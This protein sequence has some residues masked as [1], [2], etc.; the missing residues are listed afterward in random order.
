MKTRIILTLLLM[1]PRVNANPDDDYVNWL[2]SVCLVTTSIGL[3]SLAVS[4][5][6]N[7]KAN[8]RT[9]ESLQ[10]SQANIA[11]QQLRIEQLERTVAA[12]QLAQADIRRQQLRVDRLEKAVAARQPTQ[13]SLSRKQRRFEG[14]EITGRVLQETQ[15]HNLSHDNT[16]TESLELTPANFARK[17]RR[18]E[19]L[20]TTIGVRKDTREHYYEEVD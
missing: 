13:A 9:V 12:H 11:R 17:Q 2:Q 8:Q 10:Q 16:E 3:V 7:A 18:L 4:N 5:C 19:A 20:E 14:L 1:M 15:E 6:F